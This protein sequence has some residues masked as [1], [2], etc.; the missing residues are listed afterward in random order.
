M[1]KLVSLTCQSLQRCQEK[2]PPKKTLPRGVRSR[3]SVRLETGLGLGSGW[4]FF[5]SFFFPRTVSRYWAKFRWGIYDFQISGQS[6]IKE[7]CRNYRNSDDIDMKIGPVT[8][9]VKK[10][11]TRLK[12]FADDIMLEYCDV[13]VIFP[14][15]GQL[16]DIRKTDSGRIVWKTFLEKLSLK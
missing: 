3:V 2:I 16:G 10:N 13:I 5:R 9:L 1:P 11:K 15:Y 12:K 7:K 14:I 4:F 6:L 8:K